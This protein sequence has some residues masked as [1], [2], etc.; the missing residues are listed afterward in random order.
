MELTPLAGD[1]PD[2]R[3]C[4]VISKTDRGTIAVQGYKLTNEELAQIGPPDGETVVEIP[5]TLL[6]EAARAYGT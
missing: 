3:T 2:G 5:V 1:C 4:P 6:L